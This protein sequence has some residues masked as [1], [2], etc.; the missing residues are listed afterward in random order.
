MIKKLCSI[1][2]NEDLMTKVD[3]KN[4]CTF[5]VGGT[6]EYLIT[7]KTLDD[8]CLYLRQ[9][10]KL[11]I[12]YKILGN[13]SN[14]LPA[15]N[16]NYGVFITTRYILDEPQFFGNWLVAYCGNNITAVA[17]KSVNLG[18][19]GLECL[20]GIPATVGGAIVNNAGAFETTISTHIE[21]LLVYHKGKMLCK[22]ASF[23][24]FG[25]RKS[26]FQNAEYVILGATFKLD[27][28]KVDTLSQKVK[29]YLEWR[30]FHQPNLPSAGS[31]F[32]KTSNGI[33]AGE[34]IDKLGLKGKT[35][36]G[37]QVSPVHANF[38]V[39]L[40]GA[41]SEDIKKLVE[42]IQNKVRKEYSIL[43]HREIEYL[44]ENNADKSRLSYT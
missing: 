20:V 21:S 26:I 41:T 16:L 38:I 19:S 15:D 42:F 6:L 10:D 30:K 7:P 23:G 17:I 13:M 33:S 25:Y 3:V 18:L 11:N 2:K 37:A 35:I 43:L 34:I 1:I 5:K 39:N 27:Y 29:Q 8:F 9:L 24:E 28:L 12:K 22:P 36:G 31:I 44:G 32:K 14:I 4:L 40:G